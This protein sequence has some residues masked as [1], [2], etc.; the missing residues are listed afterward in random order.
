LHFRFL[1]ISTHRGVFVTLGVGIGA[2]LAVRGLHSSFLSHDDGITMLGVTCNQGRYAGGTPTQQW[3]PAGVWQDY[4]RLRSPG[5]FDQIRSDMANFD[6]HPPLYFWAL[7]LWFIAFGVSLSSA[8]TLNLVFIGV[9]AVLIIA[10]CRVLSVPA[11]VIYA[12]V[13]TWALTMATRA[14]DVAVRQYAL[15]GLFAALLL[16]LTVLWLQHNRFGYLAAMAPVVAAGVLTQFLFVVPAG[17]VFLAIGT[18]LVTGRRYGELAALVASYAAAGAAFMAAAPD[19]IESVHRGGAQAQ[20]FSWGA[21]PLRAAASVAAL[22]ETFLPLDPTYHA[23]AVS[24]AGWLMAAAVVIPILVMVAR[25]WWRNRHDHHTIA[26][27]SESVPLL[28]FLG[29]WLTMVALFLTFI[30]PQHTMRPLYLYFLTPFLA[31]GL[32]VAAQRSDAVIRT[33]SAL[34]VFQLVGVTIATAVFVYLQNRGERLVPGANAAIVLDS[35]RRG[36]VPATLWPVASTAQIYAASQDQLL[37]RFPDLSGAA[38]RELYYVSKV[39]LGDTYGNTVGKRKT[40]LKE[41]ADRGYVVHFLGT[42]VAM[43][44]TEVYRLTRG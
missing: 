19:F 24:V 38:T 21:L 9:T 40:L 5:C 29:S 37:A 14:A 17:M 4:W 30:D 31:V 36:V 41:F 10:T 1:Q 25:W 43:G 12:V 32:A 35:D 34:F 33:I 18:T 2:I 26:L 16:F 20:P 13:L 22:V 7:H 28:V 44:D 11:P 8:L 6:I 27:T 39:M 15:L 3:G 42:S 23:D